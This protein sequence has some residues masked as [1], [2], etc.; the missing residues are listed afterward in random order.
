MM[1]G[2]RMRAKRFSLGALVLLL[3]VMAAAEPDLPARER[4]KACDPAVA[5]A[6]AREILA[7]PATLREPLEMFMPAL[8]LFQGREQD[9]AVFW[10]YAAQLRTRYQLAFEQGDRG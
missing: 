7:D 8:V 3:P 6:A 2:F 1:K 10:L 4:L 5:V 9:D